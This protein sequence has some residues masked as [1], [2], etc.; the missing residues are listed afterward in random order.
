MQNG[1]NLPMSLQRAADVHR[2]LLSVA[3]KFLSPSFRA[4]FTRKADE[5]YSALIRSPSESLAQQY[6]SEQLATADGLERVVGIYN[7]YR[8]SS[9]TL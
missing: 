3:S 7:A 6:I 5:D 8:D 1:Q 4:F 9:S 2:Q